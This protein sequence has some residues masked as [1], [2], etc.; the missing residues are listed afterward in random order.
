VTRLEHSIVIEA[1]INEVF[2]Y[3][4]D[5]QKWNEWFEGVSPFEPITEITRGNGARYKY[6][7]KLIGFT[8]SLETEIND[9]KENEGWTGVAIKGM[10]HRTFWNFEEKR[11]NSTK[12]SYGLEYKLPIPVF[13]FIFD[14]LL[15]KPQWNKIIQT[16]LQNL[17]KRLKG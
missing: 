11:N 9:F 12:F 14:S 1:P 7:A 15:L 6:K 16:S 10:P 17:Q 4:S 3:T 2:A 8:A 13:G 5:W